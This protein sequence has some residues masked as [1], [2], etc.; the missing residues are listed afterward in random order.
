MTLKISNITDFI[1]HRHENILLD[2][3]FKKED[4]NLEGALE[5]KI[6]DN[7]PLNRQLF[8]KKN[9]LNKTVLITP[10]FMEIMAL[11]AIVIYNN[12]DKNKTAVFVSI[13]SFEFFNDVQIN[14]LISGNVEFLNTKKGFI[15]CRGVLN[16][17]NKEL[18]KGNLSAFFV[19]INERKPELKPSEI[20]FTEKNKIDYQKSS[21]NKEETMVICD[22]I[23]DYS[24][25]SL[26]ATY[27]YDSTHPLVKGHFPGNP[28]MMGVMQWLS[29]EDCLCHYL[30]ITN[31]SGN[32]SYSCSAS[33]YNQNKI[34]IAD[35][36]NIIVESWINISSISNQTNI[37][38]TGKINFRNMVSPEDTLFISIFNITKQ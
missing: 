28:I 22:S 2:H 3:I 5:L 21:R 4:T 20:D 10:F 14:D 11:A 15:T 34:K 9:H 35:I 16:N 27:K 13:S 38:K 25:T 33:I 24:D 30:E 26:L 17:N 23:I 32:N 1:P 7:D 19:D 6:T 18:C 36:K 29:I 8:Y 12:T 31:Q 37:T